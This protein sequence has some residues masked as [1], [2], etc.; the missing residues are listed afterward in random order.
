[1]A[2]Q[3]QCQGDAWVLRISLTFLNRLSRPSIGC[4]LSQ[5]AEEQEGCLSQ[6]RQLEGP[7]LPQL[8]SSRL[9]VEMPALAARRGECR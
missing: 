8:P 3:T 9:A 1:M 4:R 7:H 2:E 6:Q 5:R